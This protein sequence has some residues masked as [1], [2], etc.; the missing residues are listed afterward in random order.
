MNSW[1]IGKIQG[2]GE[3]TGEMTQRLDT[4]K[5]S[6]HP[7]FGVISLNEQIV[8]QGPGNERLKPHDLWGKREE[9][10]NTTHNFNSYRIPV[11]SGFNIDLFQTLAEGHED[12][13]MFE[14]L[15]YGF[16]LDVGE[17]FDPAHNVINHSSAIKFPEQVQKYIDEE[18]QYGALK[19]ADVTKFKFLHKS[20]LMLRPKEGK[21]RRIILHL[22]WPKNPGASVKAC[23][24]EN[25]YLNTEFTLKLP[26]VD[27]ICPII[28]AF[29]VPVMLYKFD[30]AHAFRQIP[31]DPLDVAYLGI[32]WGGND[33]IDTAL[34]F[35]FRHGSA[36]CQRITDAVRFILGKHGIKV[37]NYID[38]LLQLCRRLRH[39]A[40]FSLL[41]VCY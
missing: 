27:T 3:L 15:R 24:P 23:V 36:I 4:M 19:I 18:V 39:L 37:I 26:T 8:F 29:E 9:G 1:I 22:S 17:E 38:D 33:Y 31:I 16:P 13:Q 21:N 34:E 6:S 12:M 35:G 41:K 7:M 28:N 32:N 5:I 25:R 2:G 14:L 20:P 40:H 30:L 11:P 10:D